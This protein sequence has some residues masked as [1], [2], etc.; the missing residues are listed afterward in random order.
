MSPLSIPRT[1]M[2]SVASRSDAPPTVPTR[3]RDSRLADSLARLGYLTIAASSSKATFSYGSGLAPASLDV[4]AGPPSTCFVP[5]DDMAL[6][7]SGEGIAGLPRPAR[8]RDLR[9]DTSPRGFSR[10]P[11]T[12]TALY[13]QARPRARAAS[14]PYRRAGIAQRA[15]GLRFVYPR[16][17]RARRDPL[18]T[19]DDP[20]GRGRGLL[21]RDQGRARF[22]RFGGAE[23]P[24]FTAR[25][26]DRGALVPLRRG[27]HRPS[28]IRRPTALPPNALWL[29]R[30]RP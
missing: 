26:R 22:P 6:A 17:L 21:P 7:S 11:T 30:Q 12:S 15:T 19:R 24:G 2:A 23:H 8:L 13:E 4:S 16:V 1:L 5:N 29:A 28:Q 14:R 9:F 27:E 25:P 18:F 10:P 3:S 20:G